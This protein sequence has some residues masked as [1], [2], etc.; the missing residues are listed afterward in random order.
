M[1]CTVTLSFSFY[2]IDVGELINFNIGTLLFLSLY[3]L[4]LLLKM[5]RVTFMRI[6]SLEI[7]KF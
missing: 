7:L 2:L 3:Y 1:L 4:V 5:G 6:I